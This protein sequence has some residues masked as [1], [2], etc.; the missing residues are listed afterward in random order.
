M[1]AQ[2]VLDQVQSLAR[3]AALEAEPHGYADQLVAELAPAL[4][5]DELAARDD[6]L[7]D[8]LARID[9]LAER[10]MRIRLDHVLADDQA[11]AVPTRKVFA[12][13]VTGYVDRLDLLETRAHDVA[14]RGGSRDAAGIARLVVEAARATLALRTAIR[15]DVF[16]AISGLA[17]TSVPLADAQ[18]R[19]M[20][21]EEVARRAWSALRRELEA[22]A[23]EP[24]RVTEGPL[25]AR[26]GTWPEQLDDPDPAGEPTFASLIELD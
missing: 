21:S 23:A 20:R 15:V 10:V 18:A 13:T 26:L 12:A 4:S 19:D 17:A 7:R 8:A 1:S 11:I 9:A 14:T 5:R 25:A 3:V 16:V 6:R 2:Q 22:V 24:T